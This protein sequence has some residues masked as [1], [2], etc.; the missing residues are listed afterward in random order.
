MVHKGRRVWSQGIEAERQTSEELVH[1]NYRGYEVQVS[2]VWHTSVAEGASH[3]APSAI[4]SQGA[5][6]LLCGEDDEW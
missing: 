3:T 4:G 5:T 2:A 1:R 6:N